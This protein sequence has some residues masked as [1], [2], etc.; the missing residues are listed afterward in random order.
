MLCPL[1]L[2][3]LKFLFFKLVSSFSTNSMTFTYISHQYLFLQVNSAD[4]S[5]LLTPSARTPLFST[6]NLCKEFFHVYSIIMIVPQ[7]CNLSSFERMLLR[8]WDIFSV[9]CQCAPTITQKTG[10]ILP[11]VFVLPVSLS[12]VI[13][14]V[15]EISS[16]TGISIFI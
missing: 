4:F 15:T 6:R 7:P 14:F 2:G 5:P 9:A 1:F 10:E 12:S 3:C 8:D 16:Q 13:L 11:P